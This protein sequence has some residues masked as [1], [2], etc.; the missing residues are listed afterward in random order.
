M[1]WA[2]NAAFGS[3]N[4]VLEGS[5]K[6]SAVGVKSM[7]LVVQLDQKDLSTLDTFNLSFLLVQVLQV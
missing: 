2:S 5:T 1:P 7:N 4:T 3:D 6:M